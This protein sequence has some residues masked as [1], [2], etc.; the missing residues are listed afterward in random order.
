M[1]TRDR[2]SPTLI[3]TADDFGASPQVNGAILRAHREGVLTAASLI[4]PAPAAEEAVALARACPSLRVGLHLTLVDGCCALAPARLPGIVDPRGRFPA[5]PLAAGLRYGLRPGIRGQLAAEIC[6]Q[7]DGF[8]ATGLPLDHV[9]GHHHL[10]MH[11][12]LWPLVMAEAERHAAAGIR[13]T[14]EDLRLMMAW[15]RRNL[16]LRAAHAAVLVWLARR[17]RRGLVGRRLR[18]VPRVYGVLPGGGLTEAYLLWLV[19]AMPLSDAEII[20]HPGAEKPSSP[21][22]GDAETQALTS[23]ALRE[24]IDERGFKLGGYAAIPLPGTER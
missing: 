11:P 15:D 20:F 2:H 14:C 7:F 1:P 17:C 18:H 23:P 12:I 24:A 6:A 13:V 22:I 4:V 21:E 3:L 19:R 5:S 16:A 9:T 10:H 8:A